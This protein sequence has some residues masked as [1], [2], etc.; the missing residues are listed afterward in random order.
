M[1]YFELDI[2]YPLESTEYH[3]TPTALLSDLPEDSIWELC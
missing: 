2:I 1:F 3:E